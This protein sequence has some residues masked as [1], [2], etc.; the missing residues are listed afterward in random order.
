MPDLHPR[1]QAFI[2]ALDELRALHLK[3]GADY[4]APDDPFANI[5]VSS[6]WGIEPWL[7]AIMR[8]TDKV[9]RLQ[10]Y[11]R[12]GTLANEGVED[13]LADLA[14]YALIALVLFRETVAPKVGPAPK[15][16]TEVRPDELPG[17]SVKAPLDPFSFKRPIDYRDLV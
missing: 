15:P 10:S 17:I 16:A 7:G 4:G 5:S 1:S 9:V 8:G 13:A 3:K 2:D 11:A 14:A 6:Q 12:T